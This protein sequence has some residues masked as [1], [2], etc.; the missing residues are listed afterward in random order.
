LNQPEASAQPTR[1]RRRKLPGWRTLVLLAE[2]I[3]C[4]TLGGCIYLRL[5]ELRN[6]LAGFDRYFETDLRDGVKIICRQPVLLDEDMAFFKLVPE[7]RERVGTAE[8]WRFRWVKDYAVAD[9]DP[10]IYEVAVDFIFVD[11]KLTRVILP[12]R[13]FAFVPKQ[14]FLMIVRAFGH[15]RIDQERRTASTSVR[16]NLGPNQ[17]PR[18]LA[19]KDLMALLGAPMETTTT[20]AGIVWHYR[21]RA[22][23]R[24]QHSG[25]IDATF[26]LDPASSWVRRIQGRVFDVTLDIAFPD[27]TLRPPAGIK[28]AANVAPP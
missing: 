23:S 4:L 27:S 21:Y 6:Q 1:A 12:E 11:H 18:Q 5:L 14:F 24:R 7:S 20:D 8:R 28:P 25:R 15:A 2:A 3:V 17:I 22:A 9:E 26:T 10:R 16:E 13:L 19:R